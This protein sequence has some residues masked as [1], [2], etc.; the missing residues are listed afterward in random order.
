M[1]ED[2]VGAL[3]QRY[4]PNGTW[5]SDGD[6]RD[7]SALPRSPIDVF[8]V[9]ATLV[10]R[11]GAYR[12]LVKPSDDRSMRSSDDFSVKQLQEVGWSQIARAWGAGF[13]PRLEKSGSAWDLFVEKLRHQ[14]P[15]SFDAVAY[16]R[17]FDKPY[18]DFD[19]LESIDT[20]PL[21]KLWTDVFFDQTAPVV[22]NSINSAAWWKPCLW[23]MTLADMACGGVGFWPRQ[24]NSLRSNASYVQQVV[25]DRAKELAE[26]SDSKHR[27]LT[28][29][30]S[31]LVDDTLCAVLPKTRTSSLGC[32][33]RSMTHNLALLPSPGVV[34]ARWRI[35]SAPPPRPAQ[36]VGS[37]KSS[38][39]SKPLNLLLIPFPY[40][41]GSKCFQPACDESALADESDWGFFDLKQCWLDREG[42]E[43]NDNE[44]S[45]NELLKFV[46][47]LHKRAKAD[48]HEIHAIVFP[49]YSLDRQAFDVLSKALLTPTGDIEFLVAGLSE[50]PGHNGESNGAFSAK[51]GNF[52]AVR[53]RPSTKGQTDWEGN[54]SR[55]KHHRWKLDTRQIERYGLSNSLNPKHNWW[56]GIPLNR[57]TI[58][59]FVPRAGTSMTVLICEDLARADPVQT[60]VRS[61]GPNLVLALLMD[62]PQ[63]KF[64]WPGHY[65]GVL[66]DDPGC[67]VL[68]FTSLALIAR[69]MTS[70]TD[71]SRSIAF[72]R[73]SLGAERELF[74]P[75]GSH[76]LAL[77]M[78]AKTKTEHSLDGR[79]DDGAAFIWEL[80]EVTPVR[81]EI[82]ASTRWIVEG[83]T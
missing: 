8:A 48:L 10:E 76:A 31:D 49:E 79:G 16:E 42:Q 75:Q 36:S 23:L 39:D 83:S 72:F 45:A 3:L 54:H 68:T 14:Y 62:G 2:T 58:D 40:R 69:G 74:L 81:A 43:P 9:L 29:I 78:C 47:A 52:V 41:F 1:G 24:R 65:A 46:R 12:Q 67:S 82:D 13:H 63:R 56:E 71:Q 57:R 70:D 77:R 55:E 38:K 17:E 20:L 19:G 32:T 11:S 5:R 6:A 34:E 64:R 26:G 59:F 60:V 44:T 51:R 28:T 7:W 22:A 25:L 27:M 30:A 80:R 18:L 66:A 21:Q 15:S 50:E 61:I 53:G 33:L 35:P 73:N 4:M 37:G